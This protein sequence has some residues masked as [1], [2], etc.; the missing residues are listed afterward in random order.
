MTAPRRP[1][2]V[3]VVA[4]AGLVTALPRAH[5]GP[6][7]W[8]GTAWA[9]YEASYVHRRGDGPLAGLGLAG[10]RLRGVVGRRAPVGWMLGLDLAAGATGPRGFAYQADLYLLGLGVKLGQVGA[11]GLG[12]GVGASGATG[13]LDDAVALPLEGFLHLALGDH[14]R[15]MARGR[16]T[17]VAAADARADG[18]PSVGWADELD[19]TVALRLGHR[20]REYGFPTGNG[21]FAGVAYRETMGERMLGAVIG[22]SLDASSR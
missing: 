8:T 16:I 13:T 5:A 2:G 15:L 19:G 18:A 11:L 21:W 4:F 1:P 17:W 10:L 14:L 20:Y 22:Y 12:T 6:E 9:Q 3:L 7:D